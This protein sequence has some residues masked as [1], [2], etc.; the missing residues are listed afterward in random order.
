MISRITKKG[1]WPWLIIAL[2]VLNLG[3]MVTIIFKMSP[4]S[5]E[6]NEVWSQRSKRSYTGRE[7][8]LTKHLD[9]SDIQRERFDSIRQVQRKKNAIF[10]NEMEVLKKELIKELSSSNPDTVV[11]RKLSVRFGKKHSEQKYLT[12]KHFIDIKSICSED[13]KNILN[14]DIRRMI[15]EPERVTDGFLRRHNR[16]NRFNK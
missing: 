5:Y 9:M 12:F 14:M 6:K 7:S 3:A 15:Y 8:G 13:Q 10:I 2:L 4:V 1:I 11:L 16:N